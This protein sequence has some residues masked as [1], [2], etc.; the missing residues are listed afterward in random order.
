MPLLTLQGLE[1]KL[2][3]PV[4]LTIVFALG[5]SLLLSLTLVP[6][7]ASLLLKEH[8][9]TEPWVMRWATRLYQPL[10]EAA[11]HHPLRAS[12]VAI[13][14]LALGV[15]AYLG[16]GKAFM[17]TMDE[18]DILLQLQKPP[19]IGLQRSLEIDLAVQKAIGAAVPEVRHSIGRVGS[20][21]LGL[22]PM[23]L[24]ETD[25]F[26]QL[27]P[28]KDWHAADKDALSAE[29]RKVMDAFP[30]L[31]FGF[32]QPIEMRISEMLTGSRGDVAVKLFGP[33][34]QTLGDL[35]QRMA[36]RIE[37]V[38]GARDVLTQASDSVEY[39]QVKVDAQAAGRAGLAVTQVQDELRAQLEGVPAGLVIEPD[40]RTPIVVRGDAR[41]RGSAER[42]KDLQLARGDQG[43]IPWPRWRASPPPMA[44]CWCGARTAR[45][46]R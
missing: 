46:S 40:R 38:P 4:A 39:L 7:L 26:M 13:A 41:L 29:I 3:V 6:V 5:V 2:F 23:G 24:N 1:G 37:K 10:L 33:D 34:L 25:L 20:D 9:H 15:V 8:A 22:D 16:T 44:P 36:A 28:R 27:A 14:A 17:P 19:S 11:L 43:E 32:T 30:G 31:E 21:E 42:F 35:A 45:A 12:A 18:G